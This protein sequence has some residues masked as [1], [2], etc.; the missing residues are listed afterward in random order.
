[1]EAYKESD[2][3]EEFPYTCHDMGLTT[4]SDFPII[5]NPDNLP[6]ILSQ[7][8]KDNFVEFLIEVRKLMD[9]FEYND[10]LLRNSCSI[11][12]S[13]MC[14][15]VKGINFMDNSFIMESYFSLIE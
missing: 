14:I 15:I 4:I 12:D 2:V 3:K 13:L 6:I 5:T 7:L 10:L 9:L 11:S 1:M 8:P